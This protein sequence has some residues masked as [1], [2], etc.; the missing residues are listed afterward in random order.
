MHKICR[1]IVKTRSNY[2]YQHKFEINASRTVLA[3]VRFALAS[4]KSK[5]EKRGKMKRSNW[6]PICI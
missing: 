4:N 1:K 3:F 2:T 5:I 6:Q